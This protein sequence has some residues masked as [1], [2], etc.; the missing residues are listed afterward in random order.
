MPALNNS[1]SQSNLNA[2]ASRSISCRTEFKFLPTTQ[3]AKNEVV[4]GKTHEVQQQ[5][6]TNN[7][8]QNRSNDSNYDEQQTINFKENSET[9]KEYSAQYSAYIDETLVDETEMTAIDD[10]CELKEVDDSVE[11][12]SN[13]D[14]YHNNQLPRYF[15]SNKINT[16]FNRE[17]IEMQKHLLQQEFHEIQ[18]MRRQRHRYE[19]E[20]LQREL[21][22]KKS[23]HSKKL[24]LLDRKLLYET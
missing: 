4:H 15:Q 5:Q 19:I 24:E 22:F 10:N 7:L 21:E 18:N 3:N 13:T 17:L 11:T 20:I 14:Y 9:N 8:S 6:I 23:E 12:S 16:N 2:D 1:S